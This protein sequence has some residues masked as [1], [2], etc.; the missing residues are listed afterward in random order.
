M[1]LI[2]DDWRLKLLAVGLAVLMLGAVAFSQNPPTVGSLKVPVHYTTP[3]NLILVNPPTSITV[4]YSG[5]AETIKNVNTDNTFATV[6]ATHANP[7]AAVTL[8]VKVTTISG[9]S[10]QNVPPIVVNVDTLKSKDLAVQ[11]TAHTASEQRFCVHTLERLPAETIDR[12]E[13]LSDDDGRA[14]AEL[15][16][17]AFDAMAD[18]LAD[19]EE[20]LGRIDAIAGDGDHGRGM[21]KGSSAAREAAARAVAD[22]AGQGSVLT[23][24]GRQWAAKAG[25][26]SG[27]LWGAMLSALGARLGDRGRPDSGTVAAGMRDGYDALIQLGGASPGDKTMLDALLPFVEELERRVSDGEPWQD[28]WR[29]A[30]DIATDAARATADLRPRIG[31]ARP[32]AERSIGT[33][34][35]GAT[36]LA[37]CACT[38]ANCFVLTAK[39]DS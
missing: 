3:P 7:G 16:A 15:V 32:L 17:R 12:I 33:P 11:V 6:D 35:A 22:G 37:M 39:G 25:G 14:G 5:L 31:R 13:E 30:A 38:V 23:A 27:V 2:T 10:V 36:S 24:A 29:A 18:M 4:S 1:N 26:T 21:V 34:D 19:A 28:A 20:E 8:A 9:V